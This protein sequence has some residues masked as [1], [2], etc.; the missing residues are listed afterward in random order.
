MCNISAR[1]LAVLID[2]HCIGQFAVHECFEPI[3]GN[4][5]VEQHLHGLGQQTH[6]H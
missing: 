3:H 6:A 4:V 2:E 5:G 1:S